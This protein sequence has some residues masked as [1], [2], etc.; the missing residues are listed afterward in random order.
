M[1]FDTLKTIIELAAL[2]VGS[3]ASGTVLVMRNT[4]KAQK[5]YIETL[6]K[7][8]KELKGEFNDLQLLHSNTLL[9]VKALEGRIDAI[10]DIPLSDI[11]ETLKEMSDRQLSFIENFKQ[12]GISAA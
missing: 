8:N 9:T 2:G 11:S 12:K 1:D 10:K 4:I 3:I 6:E 7:K 5:D